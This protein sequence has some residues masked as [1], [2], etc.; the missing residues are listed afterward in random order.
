MDKN[1]QNFSIEDARALADSPLGQQLFGLL[2]TKNPEAVSQA[3]SGN[4]D[5]LRNS[6]GTLLADPEIRA[7]LQQLGGHHG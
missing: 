1:S 7:L 4:Y 3:V 6:L 5:T 2:Q